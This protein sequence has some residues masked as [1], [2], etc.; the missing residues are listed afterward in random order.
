M[1][2]LFEGSVGAADRAAH[3]FRDRVLLGGFFVGERVSE[4]TEIGRFAGG[5]LHKGAELGE[6][7]D[8]EDDL[9][10]DEEGLGAAFAVVAV[11]RSDGEGAARDVGYFDGDVFLR[12]RM[13]RR[14]SEWKE[15]PVAVE[16]SVRGLGGV[17]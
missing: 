2:L 4:R 1:A 13:R 17:T 5:V 6:I 12:R 14:P 16:A 3:T 7:A 8:A 9:A 15:P 10:L 11:I